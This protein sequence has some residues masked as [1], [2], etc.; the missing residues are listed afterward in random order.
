MVVFPGKGQTWTSVVSIMNTPILR[1]SCL[2]KPWLAMSKSRIVNPLDTLRL[3]WSP[4]LS[5]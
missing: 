3:T 5:S 2:V 4:P 1:M